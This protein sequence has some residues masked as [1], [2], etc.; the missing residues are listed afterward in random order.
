MDVGAD[1]P[2]ESRSQVG[3]FWPLQDFSFWDAFI[4]VQTRTS[5]FICWSFHFNGTQSERI[6]RHQDFA[7]GL[8]DVGREARL[9]ALFLFL[10]WSVALWVAWFCFCV[11]FI[12][13]A[14]PPSEELMHQ[15]WQHGSI[16]HY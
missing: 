9:V 7:H 6:R 1:V 11:T 12:L 15:Q 4:H 5:W 2:E 8:F 3:T 10:V 16:S 14:F 13:G